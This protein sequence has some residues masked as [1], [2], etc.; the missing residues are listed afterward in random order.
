MV[1]AKPL[2]PMFQ[3][4]AGRKS[5]GGVPCAFSGIREIFELTSGYPALTRF[6]SHPLRLGV[7]CFAAIVAGQ[8]ILNTRKFCTDD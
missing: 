6:C 5:A 3:Q 8:I 4:V 1:T 2:Y 7:G